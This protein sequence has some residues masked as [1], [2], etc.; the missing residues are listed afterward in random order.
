MELI[1]L[2]SRLL[3]PGLLQLRPPLASKLACTS[4]QLTSRQLFC[5]VFFCTEQSAVAGGVDA[6]FLRTEAHRPPEP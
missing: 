1:L 3:H 4:A 5:I 6:L 2:L